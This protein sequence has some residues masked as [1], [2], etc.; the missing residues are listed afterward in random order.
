MY[1]K[2]FSIIFIFCFLSLLALGV[3]LVISKN[4]TQIQSAENTLSGLGSSDARISFVIVMGDETFHLDSKKGESLYQALYEA[5]EKEQIVFSGL[6]YP[7][8]GFFVT[9]IGSLRSGKGKNLMYYINGQEAKVGV[10]SYLPQ[11]GDIISWEL[12]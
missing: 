6:R 4:V 1:K 5:E 11:E 8:L 9:S 12:K 7:G 2:P 10:S 3:F